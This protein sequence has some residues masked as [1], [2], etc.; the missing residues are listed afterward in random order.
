MA[1]VCNGNTMCLLWGRN[2]DFIAYIIYTTFVLTSFKK[3][4]ELGW[5]SVGSALH[6]A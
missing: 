1:G 6:L 5:H 3:Y 4:K 2:R